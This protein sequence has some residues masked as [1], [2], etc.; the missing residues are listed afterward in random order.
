[1]N[2]SLTS[3]EQESMRTTLKLL[4]R[5]K[6]NLEKL[7]KNKKLIKELLLELRQ[8]IKEE[9]IHFPHDTFKHW[10]VEHF[11]KHKDALPELH[12]IEEVMASLSQ[13]AN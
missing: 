13:A 8:M 4:A 11:H 1:M 7:E 2:T 12:Y 5:I 6:E 10:I 9:G 3:P